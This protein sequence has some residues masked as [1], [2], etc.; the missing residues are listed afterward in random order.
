[1]KIKERKADWLQ[2]PEK[3]AQGVPGERKGISEDEEGEKEKRKAVGPANE[4]RKSRLLAWVQSVLSFRCLPSRKRGRYSEHMDDVI[5]ILSPQFDHG[6][7]F[8]FIHA[9]TRPQLTMQHSE[10]L[11]YNMPQ[12]SIFLPA[13]EIQLLSLEISTH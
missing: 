5:H 3:H 4:K 1:M 11:S 7:M 8:F 2:R 6:R 12:N 9:A 10:Y 13:Q